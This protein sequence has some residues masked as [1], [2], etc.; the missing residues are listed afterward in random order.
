MC[1]S[2]GLEEVGLQERW[3]P[4]IEGGGKTATELKKAWDK[5]TTEA[6]EISEYLGEELSG[7]LSVSVEGAGEGSTDGSTRKAL[8]VQLESLRHKTRQVGQ[9]SLVMAKQR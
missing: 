2:L 3:R 6:H 5:L 7:P 8:V 9:A 4:L 1:P